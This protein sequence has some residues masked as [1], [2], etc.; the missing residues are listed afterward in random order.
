MMFVRYTGTSWQKI[1]NHVIFP[2]EL[3]IY[4]YCK[5]N[6]S[7]T[8]LNTARSVVPQV[9]VINSHEDFQYD[10][11]SMIVHHGTGF[12]SGHYTAYCWNNEAG[13]SATLKFQH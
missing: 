2:L 3:N 6:T 1:N 8:Q 11:T 12:T 5:H 7:S 13:I 4:E 9:V 10:L